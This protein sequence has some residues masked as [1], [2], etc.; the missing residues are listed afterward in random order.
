MTQA[1]ADLDISSHVGNF[2]PCPQMH[3]N[4]MSKD[5]ALMGAA[6]NVGLPPPDD[7]LNDA[8]RELSRSDGAH[9]VLRKVQTDVADPRAAFLNHLRQY[10]ERGDR[11]LGVARTRIAP[12]V[13][14]HI[15][16]SGHTAQVVLQ[17]YA[18]CKQLQECHAAP[19]FLV[20]AVFW[21]IGCAV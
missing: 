7:W 5:Q 3:E 10:D 11:R 13:L 14:A 16:L 17:E 12:K 19:D 6:P 1:G 15:S 4:M 21:D 20:L 8:Q 2:V 18:A 9:E